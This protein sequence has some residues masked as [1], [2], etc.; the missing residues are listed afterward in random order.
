MKDPR[1]QLWTSRT[2]TESGMTTSSWRRKARQRLSTLMRVLSS[3]LVSLGD[4]GEE[5]EEGELREEAPLRKLRAG[6]WNQVND[7][8]DDWEF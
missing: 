3:T 2:K 6:N 1:T 7:D 4:G 8:Y 5:E